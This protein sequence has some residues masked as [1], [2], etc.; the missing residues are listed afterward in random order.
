MSCGRKFWLRCFQCMSCRT[1]Y[2]I[3]KHCRERYWL[4]H[5]RGRWVRA[6]TSHL[7][8]TLSHTPMRKWMWESNTQTCTLLTV[9]TVN[10]S[11]LGAHPWTLPVPFQLGYA[12]RS[13]KGL[14]VCMA[15]IYAKSPESQLC[16]IRVA[17]RES[18]VPFP[19][20]I[21]RETEREKKE[22]KKGRKKR[23]MKER[24]E[25][26][27]EEGKKERILIIWNYFHW[28]VVIVYIF[29][30]AEEFNS[31]LHNGELLQPKQQE[32]GPLGFCF[33]SLW[34]PTDCL[35]PRINRIN[36]ASFPMVLSPVLALR[37]M[38]TYNRGVRMLRS[39]LSICQTIGLV[40]SIW[41]GWWNYMF[42]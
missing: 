9:P 13:N 35:C 22:R 27:K 42:R 38:K 40:T 16:P 36:H 7:C 12:G 34:F 3:E 6:S 20:E 29:G 18:F 15:C 25:G 30:H 10:H 8:D 39:V 14:I 11:F 23:R 31:L 26:R 5:W 24:R 1:P 33:L 4:L 32:E 17:Q 21:L 37:R 2:G 19:I 41:L 28:W